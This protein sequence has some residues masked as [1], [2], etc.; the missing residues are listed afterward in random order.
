MIE[1]DS[2]KSPN[3]VTEIPRYWGLI[4]IAAAPNVTYA[5]CYVT[6]LCPVMTTRH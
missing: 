6:M 2:S 1:V 5:D 4:I 3:E